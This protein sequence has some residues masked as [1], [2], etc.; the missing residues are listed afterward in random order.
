MRSHN[1]HFVDDMQLNTTNSFTHLLDTENT[2]ELNVI[3]HS[4]N[5][6][7]DKL[8]ESR[9]SSIVKVSVQNLTTF[10]C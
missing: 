7:P 6:S 2:D 3:R 9:L 10:D 5:T 1:N 8:I 4:P